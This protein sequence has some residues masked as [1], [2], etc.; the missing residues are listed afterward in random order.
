MTTASPRTLRVALDASLESSRAEVVYVVT[1]LLEVAGYAAH[2]SWAP[3]AATASSDTVDIY[4]GPRRDVRARLVIPSVPWQFAS[5]PARELTRVS[6]A[7]ELDL[8]SFGG[9]ESGTAVEHDRLSSDIL[10]ASYWLL[11]GARE[12]TWPRSR[13]DDLQAAESLL[14]KEDLLARAPVSRYASW[15]RRHF[16]SLGTPALRWPWEAPQAMAGFAFTHDVDYPQIIRWIE[17][18]RTLLGG[19]PRG[20]WEI[21]TGRQS[22]WRF[23]DWMDLTRRFGTHPTF[24]FMARRGSLIQFMSGTPDAFYDVSSRPFRELFAQLK[25]GGGEIGLHASYRAYR[26]ADMLRAERERIESI[27]NV[28]VL[29]NR[30]H[31][32]HLDPDDPNETL[33]RHEQAGFMYDSSLG[34]EYYPGWR[35]GICHPF[36]PYSP[37]LRRTIDTVQ[38]PPAWMDDHFD[39]R[40][41]L[42]RIADADQTARQLLLTA[43]ALGGICVVD[44]HARGMN[45]DFFPRYGPWLARFV[46]RELPGAAMCLT[47]AEIARTYV[48]RAHALNA[49]SRDETLEKPSGPRHAVAGK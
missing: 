23:G 12:T 25:D 5:A 29:G 18:P 35:R 48:E 22:F 4:Y 24:Y 6:R 13:W 41:S 39:R 17:V 21:A 1:T 31:Y 43:Q 34:L 2:F 14:V 44:Y 8:L 7:G 10:F 30:H 46:E 15:L 26:S 16:E 42:N 40:R 20:A 27:A 37:R 11:T 45:A 19:N 36:R 9:E 32:W 3:D 28:R 47:A 33:A 38:V 49:M